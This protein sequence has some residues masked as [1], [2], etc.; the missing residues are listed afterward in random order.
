MR[1]R[2]ILLNLVGNAIK[3]TDRAGV[4]LVG[5]LSPHA[6]SG[7]AVLQFN[8][9]DTGI[10]MTPEQ[11]DRL[12]EPFTQADETTA[13]R[14]GGTG[15]GL[16]ISRTLARLLGGDI[17]VT[18]RPGEGSDF[19][20]TVAAGPLTGVPMMERPR[21]TLS[22]SGPSP[23]GGASARE[24]P[25]S[26]LRI[27]LVEDGADNQRLFSTLLRG[28]GSAVEIAEDGRL[29]LERLF[30]RAAD[31]DRAFDLVVMDMQMPEMDGYDAARALRARDC[32][33]PIIALTAH[34]MDGA[35]ERCLDAGCD[36]FLTK[37][38]R[39]DALLAA[40]AALTGRADHSA[41]STAEAR[42]GA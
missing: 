34:A 28:A 16:T 42:P 30:R 14:F 19:T 4:R 13:R 27:L 26:G 22:P 31:P 9:I 18:S 38:V 32:R 1:L 41:P 10:G 33:V 5:R 15:L 24:E 36:D 37:P 35:R 40:C 21:F 12:F 23:S 2:Q 8:V 7:E 11:I 17:T 20:V 6:P 3:F 39:R 25:L 29:A